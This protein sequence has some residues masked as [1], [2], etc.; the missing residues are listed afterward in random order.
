MKQNKLF[1]GMALLATLGLAGCSN[2]L[3]GVDPD[4]QPSDVDRKVYLNLAISGDMPPPGGTRAGAA[5]DNNG[6]PN[7]TD[8][9]NSSDFK[10]GEGQ[11]SVVEDVYFVF[12]DANGIMVGDPV[13]MNVNQFTEQEAPNPSGTVEKRY[14]QIVEVDVLKGQE[15][16]AQVMCYVNAISSDG[17]R[18]PLDQIQTVTRDGVTKTNDAGEMLFP[19]SNSV[20]YNTDFST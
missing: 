17:L 12:Y 9:P 8:D 5:G 1:Y 10:A 7:E 3:P 19:M 18:N 11:E 20:Y 13:A 4:N 2:D 6:N 14:Y 16:P 15:T